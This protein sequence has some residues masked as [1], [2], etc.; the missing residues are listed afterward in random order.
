MA[1]PTSSEQLEEYARRLDEQAARLGAVRLE[2]R[3]DVEATEAY[4]EGLVADRF[5]AHA[6]P[7]H[8]QNHID[9]AQDRLAAV[10]RLLRAAARDQQTRIGPASAPDPH[11]TVRVP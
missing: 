11:L 6:G 5:R 3:R 1:R 2:L 8:R 4:W 10:A 9:L 7:E